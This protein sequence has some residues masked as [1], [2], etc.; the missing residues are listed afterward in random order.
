MRIIKYILALIAITLLITSCG[1]DPVPDEQY[2][3]YEQYESEQIQL[4]E[5]EPPPTEWLTFTADEFPRMDGSTATIPLGEAAAA[6]LMGID[7]AEASRFVNF[8]GTHNSF[9]RLRERQ[10]DILIVYS[11]SE[12]TR[13]EHHNMDW[14]IKEPIG[15]DGLVFLVNAENPVENLTFEQVRA[16]YAGEIT[17]WSQVG[18]SDADIVAFQRNPTAGS[19]ALLMSLLMQDTPLMDAPQLNIISGMGGLM[20]VVAEFDTGRYSIG[21]NV[22]YFVTEMAQNPNIRILSIDGVT[23]TTETIASGEY[24]L[25]SHFY[26]VIRRVERDT[27]ARQMFEW[28]QSPEGQ[29]LIEQEGYAPLR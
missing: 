22:F 18:G 28:L 9:R 21:Y 23:P 13:R 4:H 3:Q 2:E 1:S 16:I 29:A 17:N 25:T 24:P 14:A 6:V 15:S 8:S 12:E 20:S 7:R 5:E 19:H 26:A 27:P 10:T 11:P